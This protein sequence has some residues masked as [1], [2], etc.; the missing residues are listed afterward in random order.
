[1]SPETDFPLLIDLLNND[2]DKVAIFHRNGDPDALGSAVA[3]ALGFPGITISTTGGL[4]L[5]AKNI[6][7]SLGLENEIIM[8]D[9]TAIELEQ[10]ELAVILDTSTPSQIEI[11]P[12]IPKL[13]ID[14]HAENAGWNQQENVTGYYS[15]SSKR[16]CAEIIYSILVAAGKDI[17]QTALSVLL[18]G[19][20]TD[21]GH[22]TFSNP[23]TLR[24]T[25]EIL[26]RSS[27]TL[28]EIHNALNTR[29]EDFSKKMAKLKAAQRLRVE[30][31]K[32][33]IIA[34]SEVNAFEGDAARAFL[35]LGADVAFIGSTRKDEY[36]VSA[37]TNSGMVKKG[38]HLG[39]L[40]ENV[41][42]EVNAQG[43]GH[44]GA[45]GL[46]GTGD[47]EAVLHVCREKFKEALRDLPD[48][49]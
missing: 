17:P 10:F 26:E 22:M 39:T 45:A 34:S 8:A 14:H 32:R 12:S 23:E 38:I 28:E 37:R 6:S 41:G 44:P 19:I 24:T 3:L 27:V 1:M 11:I 13:I 31:F 15:D 9:H 5:A 46:T 42:S 30:E 47:V 49:E 35:T 4:N 36:R 16:S 33:V 25:A 20:L 2:G 43:G 48:G 7:G 18:G 40:L 21:T 29:N